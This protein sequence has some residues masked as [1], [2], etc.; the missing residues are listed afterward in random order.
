MLERWVPGVATAPRCKIVVLLQDPQLPCNIAATCSY[1]SPIPPFVEQGPKDP[2]GIKWSQADAWKSGKSIR[3]PGATTI[4]WTAILQEEPGQLEISLWRD[5]FCSWIPYQV[6]SCASVVG[7]GTFWEWDAP[8][9]LETWWSSCK[10]AWTPVPLA[11]ICDA[12]D[13]QSS[14]SPGLNRTPVDLKEIRPLSWRIQLC[15]RGI[16]AGSHGTASSHR[17]A[18]APGLKRIEWSQWPR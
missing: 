5:P 4:L 2:P 16:Y 17:I 18:W 1:Q 12:H 8:P 6:P 13:E 7:T 10:R 3:L 15:D 11:N 14:L 9:Y